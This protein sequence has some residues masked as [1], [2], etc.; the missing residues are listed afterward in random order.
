MATML[1][2]HEVCPPTAD[3]P[4][5]VVVYEYDGPPYKLGNDVLTFLGTTRGEVDEAVQRLR[6]LGE[7]TVKE[8]M[9]QASQAVVVAEHLGVRALWVF[10]R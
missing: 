9:Y 3:E 7:T 8:A 10:L 1:N 4:S 2:Q 6:D 5:S